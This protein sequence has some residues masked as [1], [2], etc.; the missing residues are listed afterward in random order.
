MKVLL[1]IKPEYANKIF[2]G[3]KKYEYRKSL[4]KKKQ[5][6][7]VIVYATKPVGKVIGEF[8]IDKIMVGN[9]DDIWNRTKEYAGIARVD[10]CDYF[11][12]REVGFAIGI[13]STFLYDEPMEL[14]EFNSHIKYP[15][16]SFRYVVE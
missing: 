15:P 4:F 14:L 7:S 16:Q 12:E 2:T 1:S 9:P 5:V 3:E 10:Y 8:E 13:R 11:K 6:S